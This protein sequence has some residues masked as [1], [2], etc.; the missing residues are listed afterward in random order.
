M[1]TV[2]MT[3][4]L[5][6]SAFAHGEA[7]SNRDTVKESITCL[8]GHFSAEVLDAKRHSISNGDD[9]TIMFSMRH[10]FSALAMQAVR[11]GQDLPGFEIGDKNF[12]AVVV[13]Q[14]RPDAS[15]LADTHCCRT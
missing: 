8:S 10:R 5:V 9:A 12:P 1:M 7:V 15:I 2:A 3:K 13:I 4:V 11:F 6:L 14:A